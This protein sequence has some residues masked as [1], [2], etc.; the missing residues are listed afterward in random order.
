MQ[1]QVLGLGVEI[2][3]G[4]DSVAAGDGAD[5]HRSAVLLALVGVAGD[6]GRGDVA[7]DEEALVHVRFVAPGVDDE[8]AQLRAG[9]QQR[10]LIDNLAARR[11]DEASNGTWMVTIWASAR[12]SSN[13]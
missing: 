10:G 4:T 8:G 13:V 6:V 12:S 3:E 9:P 2:L 1:V 7:L 11:V 5:R